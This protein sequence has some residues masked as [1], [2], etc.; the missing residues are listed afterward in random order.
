MKKQLAMLADYNAWVNRRLYDAVALV[1]DS[2]YRADHGAFFGSLH[3]TL[4]H[5]L[6]GDR[7]WMQR[8]TGKG[9]A[10]GR[11][12]AILHE[13]FAT[14]SEA[15]RHEDRRIIDYIRSLSEARPRGNAA[16]SLDPQ[17]GGYRA[18]VG[19]AAAPLLQSPDPSPRP[20]TCH[21]DPG[22]GRRPFLRS[23]DLSA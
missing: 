7:I 14:L 6:V 8:F 23:P 5:L 18:G 11:L 16:L 15:R 1:P 3:G 22:Q 21:P 9:E 19:A 2:D 20:G 17:P 12:D 4:D 13:D 10:P